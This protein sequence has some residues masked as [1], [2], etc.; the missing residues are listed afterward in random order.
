LSY[1]GRSGHG[2]GNNIRKARRIHARRSLMAKHIDER[3]K[4]PLAK[5]FEQWQ[6]QPNRFDLPNVDTPK[7]SFGLSKVLELNTL[8]TLLL[9]AT[10]TITKWKE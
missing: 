7:K 5:S 4:A 2:Y 1:S 9:E 3:L 6:A 8:D 10:T